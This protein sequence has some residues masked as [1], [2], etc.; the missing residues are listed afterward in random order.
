MQVL[1]DINNGL[2]NVYLGRT[3]RKEINTLRRNGLSQ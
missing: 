2:P 1:T 3:D